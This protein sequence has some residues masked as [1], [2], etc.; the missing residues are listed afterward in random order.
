MISSISSIEIITAHMPD[1]KI[2]FW[3]AA[4]IPDATA[5]N[6]NGTKMLLVDGVKFVFH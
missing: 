1:P 2:L 6:P 5:V 3:I 4:S